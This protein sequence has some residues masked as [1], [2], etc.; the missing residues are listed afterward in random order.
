MRD[1]SLGF[2]KKFF[3]ILLFLFRELEV[4]LHMF[5]FFFDALFFFFQFFV[6]LFKEVFLIG[7]KVYL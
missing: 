7:E 3:C 5:I 2:F 4:S 1:L 6:R